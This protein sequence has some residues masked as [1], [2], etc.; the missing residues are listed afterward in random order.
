MSLSFNSNSWILS[1][2]M[3]WWNTF[4][5][6]Q[7]MNSS[8]TSLII[9]FFYKYLLNAMQRPSQKTV[10]IIFGESQTIF[11]V[12]GESSLVWKGFGNVHSNVFSISSKQTRHP[13]HIHF[14]HLNSSCNIWTY[15]MNILCY[16]PNTD[17]TVIQSKSTWIV[18]QIVFD[19]TR[20]YF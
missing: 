17:W 13:M 14:S 7:M 8:T 9:L 20:H 18:A 3:S 4:S 19:L 5:T 6:F 16:L 15:S 2:A 11:A 10:S 12:F 1:I